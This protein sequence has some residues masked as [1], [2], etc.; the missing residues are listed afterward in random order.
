MESR[1]I[2]A[3]L[4]IAILVPVASAPALAQ[5]SGQ[6]HL[7]TGINISGGRFENNRIMVHGDTV[8]L[9]GWSNAY[10]VGGSGLLETPGTMFTVDIVNPKNETVFHRQ[11]AADDHGNFHLA[12][13]VTD[14]FAFGMYDVRYIAEKEGYKTV[15]PY[16]PD[17]DVSYYPA[18]FYVAKTP[19]DVV[20]ADGKYKF[21]LELPGSSAEYGSGINLR[22]RLCPTPELASPEVIFGDPA[23][24]EMMWFPG[25]PVIIVSVKLASPNGT[26]DHSAQV[27]LDHDPCTNG[28]EIPTGGLVASG[29]WSASAVARWVG[30]SGDQ[31][32]QTGSNTVAFS[33]K[34]TVFRSDNIRRID[35]DDKYQSIEL[36]DVSPDGKSVLFKH[37]EGLEYDALSI[38]AL[39]DNGTQHITDLGRMDSSQGSFF[40]IARFSP[41][42]NAVYVLWD[43]DIYRQE[44]RAA[45]ATRLTDSHDITYFDFAGGRVAYTANG[46]LFFAD[47]DFKNPAQAAS[48]ANMFG[49]DL[50]PDGKKVLYQ[51]T[52]P[53]HAPVTSIAYYDLD[54]RK[55]HVVP[56]TAFCS[57]EIP[58]W[59]PNSYH[60]LFHEQSCSRGWPGGI[61]RITDLNGSFQEIIVPG[62]NDNPA[63][64]L[65]G[66]DGHSVFVSTTS[67]GLG[68][69]ENGMGGPADLY[70]ME[71]AHP[72]PEFN[73]AP[74]VMAVITGIVIVVS[75]YA[76]KRQQRPSSE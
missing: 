13:P 38:L 1:A 16:S 10:R 30:G 54:E 64:F 11:L 36:L 63:H 29:E 68:G 42:G 65:F 56:D 47:A 41:A 74:A 52:D 23:S 8:Q 15:S 7:S 46:K 67:H 48:L 49:F 4:F 50:S 35:I 5:D 24:G 27:A 62:S 70:V 69:V 40:Q 34:E 55:E 6:A 28:F 75:R 44:I 59:A 76:R 43:N 71:L 53:G 12:L 66:P 14:D 51:K 19:K 39:S 31:M 20:A 2:I 9:D 17:P 57:G 22:A 72:V 3:F 45:N 37:S 58:R 21:E 32:F 33:V 61:L 18:S 73:A 60:I 26:A 25:Q